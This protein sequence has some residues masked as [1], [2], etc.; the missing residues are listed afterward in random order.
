[1]VGIFVRFVRA[2]RP[3]ERENAKGTEKK[4]GGSGADGVCRK[5][6]LECINWGF[7]FSFESAFIASHGEIE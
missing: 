2:G 3:G 4:I 6:P 1:L 7:I 5:R